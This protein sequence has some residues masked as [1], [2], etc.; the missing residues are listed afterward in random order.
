MFGSGVCTTQDCIEFLLA[1]LL[2]FRLLIVLGLFAILFNSFFEQLSS[3]CSCSWI[4][5][6]PYRSVDAPNICQKFETCFKRSPNVSNKCLK[7]CLVSL[8]E[9]PKV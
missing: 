7:V 8:P 3:S 2:L 1:L 5:L 9:V 4:A 6:A